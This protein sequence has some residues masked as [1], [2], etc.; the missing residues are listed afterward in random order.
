[1]SLTNILFL[2]QDNAVYSIMAEAY[3]AH[4]GRGIA[5]GYS[6]GVRP[7]G[8]VH[9]MTLRTLQAVGLRPSGLHAKSASIFG[10]AGAPA[11]DMVVDMPRSG[12][13]LGPV[14]VHGRPAR[15]TWP[16]QDMFTP[17]ASDGQRLQDFLEVFSDIRM[18]VDA[19]LLDLP[20]RSG[21]QMARVA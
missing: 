8:P 13:P 20:G 7:E 18:M 21:R 14:A 5:R 4:A 15:V 3:V 9:P 1:M 2:C 16:Q 6:A 11:I 19:L 10:I 17:T 12:N